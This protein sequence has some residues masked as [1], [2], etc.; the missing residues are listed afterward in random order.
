MPFQSAFQRCREKSGIGWVNVYENLPAITPKNV[1][2]SR[3]ADRWFISFKYELE[4]PNTPKI[5]EKIGVDI[6]INS[7]A[8]C[9]D[10][11]V[12]KNRKVY[13][14]NKRKLARLQRNLA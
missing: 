5:R 6:G 11:T 2:I 3:H 9:S 13:G 8:T 1:T 4:K 7:L 10:G 12:I 14:K